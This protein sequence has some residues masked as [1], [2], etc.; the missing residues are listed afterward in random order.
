MQRR[1]LAKEK[2]LCRA[3]SACLFRISAIL[4]HDAGTGEDLFAKVK[5]LVTDQEVAGGGFA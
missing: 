4:M 5:G 1:R 3:R 2:A